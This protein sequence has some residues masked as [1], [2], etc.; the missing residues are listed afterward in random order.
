MAL[1]RGVR[2]G[3]P[4]A[5]HRAIARR[6]G[7]M[8]RRDVR[9]RHRRPV[10]AGAA[11]GSRIQGTRRGDQ[12]GAGWLLQR[13]RLADR[14]RVRLFAR[15]REDGSRPPHCAGARPNAWRADAR[16]RLRDRARGSGP[17]AVH[18]VQHGAQRGCRLPDHQ[19]H[20]GALR[21]GPRRGAA[22]DRR[23]PDVGGLRQHLRDECHVRHRAGAEP[24]PR[25]H[26]SGSGRDRDHVD[27]LV[28]RIPPDWHSAA[29]GTALAHPPAVST[30]DHVKRG[31]PRV[32]R[33][34]TGGDGARDAC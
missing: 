13:H 30:G 12:V 23:L 31:G 34:G 22:Q 14:R 11:C 15:L 33:P 9:G 6:R 24:P 20:S 17:R 27:A 1:L 25:Q 18:A 28:P 8:D 7:R 29:G 4:R 3:D 2:H 10:F 32:G 16:P 26:R 19:E 21:C 5:R